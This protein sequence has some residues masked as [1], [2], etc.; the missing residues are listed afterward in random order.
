MKTGV[1]IALGIGGFI[2]ISR[3]QAQAAQAS[4]PAAAAQNGIAALENSLLSLL[5]PSATQPAAKNSGGSG[6]N[7]AGGS[8]SGRSA[9]GTTPTM[10]V[11]SV[12]DAF[13][14]FNGPSVIDAGPTGAAF[15]PGG[16]FSDP[17]SFAENQPDLSNQPTGDPIAENSLIDSLTQSSSGVPIFDPGP[18]PDSG[19]DPG[20]DFEDPGVF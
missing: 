1:A 2:L 12:F 14:N 3:Q 5:K 6:L 10:P 18:A 16:I 19:V 8:G 13:P 4:S 9:G 7:P 20:Q 11:E 17:S 15:E